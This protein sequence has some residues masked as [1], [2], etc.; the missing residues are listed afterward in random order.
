M[1]SGS[2]TLT[3]LISEPF[4]SALK[5]VREVLAKED[6]RVPLEL[7]VTARIRKELGLSLAPCRVL[8]V[9]SPVLLLEAVT[10]DRTVAAILPLHVAL[11]GHGPHTRVHLISSSGGFHVNL[12]RELQARIVRAVEKIASRQAVCELVA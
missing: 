4:E 2:A 5:S 3:Y 1:E 11:A 7:D 6:L 8:F 9:D 12:P 10:L